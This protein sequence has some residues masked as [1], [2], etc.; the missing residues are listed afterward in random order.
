MIKLPDILRAL[1]A[2]YRYSTSGVTEIKEDICLI[3]SNLKCEQPCTD[4]LILTQHVNK[5]GFVGEGESLLF[6]GYNLTDHNPPK[7]F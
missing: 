1:K 5:A 2:H 4:G 3:W 6:V 7:M